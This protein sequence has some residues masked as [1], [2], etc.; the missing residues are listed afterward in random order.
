[1]RHGLPRERLLA[2]ADARVP[3]AFGDA[4]PDMQALK[5]SY[6][7]AEGALFEL[8]V[9]IL[10]AGSGAAE[11]A[12]RHAGLAYG[13]TKTLCTIPVQASQKKLLLPPS[14]FESRGV[15][16]AAVY[17]GKTSAEFAAALAGLREM[18]DRAL[19]QFIAAAPELSPAAW[20]AFLP[21]SLV[22]PYLK[23]MAAPS[24]DPLQ[25]VATL[26]PALQFWRIWRAALRR[27]I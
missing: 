8:A 12:A 19:Q 3:E 15:S 10:G 27:R 11:R 13:L 21:L 5:S 25:T 24:L 7:T 2:L 26:N 4:P 20:P 23:A 22:K 16:L 14:Y 6:E 18:A 1:M 9:L 17:S